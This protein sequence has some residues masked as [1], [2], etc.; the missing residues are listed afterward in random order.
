MGWGE[1]TAGQVWVFD[2]F[3]TVGRMIRKWRFLKGQI[4]KFRYILDGEYLFKKLGEFWIEWNRVYCNGNFDI[5]KM[6]DVKYIYWI[7]W[8]LKM[9]IWLVVGF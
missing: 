8:S 2:E 4:D 7:L 3:G 1:N 6:W 5:L 9:K